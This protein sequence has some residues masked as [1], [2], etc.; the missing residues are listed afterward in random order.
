MPRRLS[1]ARMALACALLTLA[2]CAADKSVS[3]AG[4][5][6]GGGATGRIGFP[7]AF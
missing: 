2:A 7:I 3:G 6:H 4:S 5:E 1:L